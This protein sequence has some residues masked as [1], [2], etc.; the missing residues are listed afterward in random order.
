MATPD[1][2]AVMILHNGVDITDNCPYEKMEL[3]DLINDPSSFRFLLQDPTTA[4]VEHDIIQVVTTELDPNHTVFVGYVVSVDEKQRGI[5]N[6]YAVDCADRKYRLQKSVVPPKLYT[7]SD[8]DIIND[9]FA[10]SFPDLSDIY[11]FSGA[12]SLIDDMA[13]QTNDESLLDAL[14]DLR[15]KTGAELS[16]GEPTGDFTITFDDGGW[17]NQL[18][19]PS[20][21]G[22]YIYNGSSPT[23]VGTIAAA[24]N[25]GNCVRWVDVNNGTVSNN[26]VM[27]LLEIYF[28]GDFDATEISF[29]YF[30]SGTSNVR[31]I[32]QVEGQTQAIA[33]TGAWHSHTFSLNSDLSAGFVKIGFQATASINLSSIVLN[34]RLDNIRVKTETA[35]ADGVSKDVLNYGG[36]FNLSDFNIDVQNGDE[37]AANIDFTRGGWDDFNAIVVTGGTANEAWDKTYPADSEDRLQLERQVTDMEVF[38]NA[39]S[40]A[41]PS[42][43]SALDLGVWGEDTLVSKDALYDSEYHWLYFASALPNLT[44]AVRITGNVQKPIRVI[45]NGAEAGKPVLAI[46]IS[47]PNITSEDEAIAKAASELSKRKAIKHIEFDTLFP[48]LRVG[49]Y[50]TVTDSTRGLEQQIKINR[51]SVKWLGSSGH[52]EFHVVCGAEEESGLDTLLASTDKQARKKA[53]AFGGTGNSYELLLASDGTPLY[54]SDNVPLLAG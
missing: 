3:E 27:C 50:I 42:W 37:Y 34:L 1:S 11:D 12:E 18:G 49:S 15:D 29:D 8:V 25:P 36:D 14:K 26:Q 30:V 6:D 32:E 5:V 53:I 2:F 33:G 28:G 10:D 41:S 46:P 47:D 23:L 17:G 51:L 48:Y 20:G 54:S 45:V 4:P 31:L 24:G 13:L 35:P 7:G 21:L 52:A 16:F 19:S 38:V 43:G 22:Y 9:L 39:G 40:D 44:K